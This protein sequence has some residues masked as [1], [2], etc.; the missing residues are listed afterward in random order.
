MSGGKAKKKLLSIFASRS[1]S[2]YEPNDNP[3]DALSKTGGRGERVPRRL[4]RPNP[5]APS[6][7]KPAAATHSRPETPETPPPLYL[8][9]WPP[10]GLDVGSVMTQGK[11]ME[12]VAT[13]TPIF[14]GI[15][16]AVPHTSDEF[17]A[18]YATVQGN[19]YGTDVEQPYT[20]AFDACSLRLQGTG[21]AK[22]PWEAL[23]QPSLAFRYGKLP[24]TVTLNYWVGM[25]G[26]LHPA[27]ELRES[28]VKPREVGLDII[29][30]RLIYLERGFED[31][32]EDLMYK[33]LYKKLLHDPEKFISPHKGKEKQIADLITVLSRHEWIDFS[34]LE[35]QVVAKFFANAMY[36]D[37]G[38]YKRFF[39]QLLLSME[40]E[41]RIQ[42]KEHSE[43]AIEKLV[44]Q[45]PPWIKWDLAVAKK[46][47]D[48]M[49]IEEFDTGTERAQSRFSLPLRLLIANTSQSDSV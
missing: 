32:Y 36:T 29:L 3:A 31:E 26:K 28:G 17:Y 13:G 22:E 43:D 11:A 37:N 4:K 14:K 19:H 48:C 23:E 18:L 12:F 5:S 16:K 41:L 30:E 38:K 24:G 20:V 45:L 10:P 25:S 35:N 49:S 42:S 9:T 44:S 7:R 2:E 46:W 33:N 6:S 15:R 40:L 34:K 39:H 1:T 8:P 27:I 21:P 47:K